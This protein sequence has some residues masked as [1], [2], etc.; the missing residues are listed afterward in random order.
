MLERAVMLLKN[1]LDVFFRVPVRLPRHPP[2][3]ETKIAHSYR[4]VETDAA[5]LCR[6]QFQLSSP[7]V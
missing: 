6:A 7:G 3:L 2:K 1:G 5:F 4:E